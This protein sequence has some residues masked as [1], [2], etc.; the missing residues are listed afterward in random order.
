MSLVGPL[1]NPN[2]FETRFDRTWIGS[3]SKRRSISLGAALLLIVAAAFL[4]HYVQ[5]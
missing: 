1:V 5:F 2:K 4:G 3:S